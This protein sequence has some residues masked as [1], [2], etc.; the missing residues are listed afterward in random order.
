[1]HHLSLGHTKAQ[2]H[3]LDRLARDPDDRIR[4]PEFQEKGIVGGGRRRSPIRTLK[5][6]TTLRRLPFRFSLERNELTSTE[7]SVK[8]TLPTVQQRFTGDWL[9]PFVQPI[10]REPVT[11][12]RSAA[13]VRDQQLV[14]GP[15]T[16]RPGFAWFAVRSYLVTCRSY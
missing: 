3:G 4:G 16:A 5:I 12:D 7:A 2:G 6:C 9:G 10:G 13:D 15:P 11:A 1:M 8:R 14:S